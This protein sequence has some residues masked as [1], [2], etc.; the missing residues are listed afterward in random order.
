MTTAPFEPGTDPSV[1]PAEVPNPVAPGEDHGTPDPVE[2][3]PE[4]QPVPDAP[5]P[6][7]SE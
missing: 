6:P 2:P 7:D 3:A 5:E 4:T 1:D